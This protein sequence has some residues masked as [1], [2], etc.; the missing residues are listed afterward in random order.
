[1][2]ETNK[3]LCSHETALINLYF[4]CA[5]IKHFCLLFSLLTN[6]SYSWLHKTKLSLGGGEIFFT[7]KL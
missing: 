7:L 6:I 5:I 4:F 1:M 3:G 2:S